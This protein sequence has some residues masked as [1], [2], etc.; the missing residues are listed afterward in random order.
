MVKFLFHWRI[1][2]IKIVIA[3]LFY[4]TLLDLYLNYEHVFL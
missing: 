3:Y 1:H 4:Y 2:V